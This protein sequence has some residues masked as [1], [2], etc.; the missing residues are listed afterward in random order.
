M[1]LLFVFLFPTIV[2]LTAA[3]IALSATQFVYTTFLAPS[4]RQSGQ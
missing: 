4:S 3:R 2:V 1:M